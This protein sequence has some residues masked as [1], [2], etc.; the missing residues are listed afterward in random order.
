MAVE[1]FGTAL[2]HVGTG[3]VFV[4][5]VAAVGTGEAGDAVEQHHDNEVGLL[6]AA[7]VVVTGVVAVDDPAVVFI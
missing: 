1:F 4:G 6:H 2:C 7:L 3:G 5:F